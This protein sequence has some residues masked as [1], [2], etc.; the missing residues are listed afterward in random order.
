[1]NALQSVSSPHRFL[2]INPDGQVAVLT[3][4]GNQNAHIVLRGGTSGPNYNSESVANC[5]A[6]HHKV[7]LRPNIMVDC[8]HANSSK[9]HNRQP[10]V[11]R[12]VGQQIMDGNRSLIGLM[13]ESHLHA[14]NQSIGSEMRYGV[15][16]TDA[17]IDWATTEDLL[18]ELAQ[19]L[20]PTLAQRD[21]PSPQRITG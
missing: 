9:D 10:H 13:I 4:R 17:C 1:L 5:E 18:V 14:G 11:A 19:R 16:V 21:R 15:S 8:S 12:D 2:G 6:A 3:T 7:G 20:G